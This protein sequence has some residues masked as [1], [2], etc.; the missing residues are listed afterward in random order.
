V[1]LPPSEREARVNKN[2]HMTKREAQKIKWEY[3]AKYEG[4]QKKG[5]SGDWK[6]DG[7]KRWLRRLFDD[8]NKHGRSA[9]E[10]MADKEVMRDLREIAQKEP[11]AAYVADLEEQLKF[12]KLLQHPDEHIEKAERRKPWRKEADREGAAA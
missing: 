3:E 1:K 7:N 10:A 6:M 9:E 11:L 4:K 5:K 8:A 2:P 12:A